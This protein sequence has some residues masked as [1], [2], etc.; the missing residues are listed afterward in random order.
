VSTKPDLQR[1]VDQLE[2]KVRAD[3]R[4]IE[5]LRTENYDLRWQLGMNDQPP[6]DHDK[7]FEPSGLMGVPGYVQ[8]LLVRLKADLKSKGRRH[9]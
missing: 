3:A 9:A 1:R 5:S 6:D 7:P 4:L 2:A 8:D